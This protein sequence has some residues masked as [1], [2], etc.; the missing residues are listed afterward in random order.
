MKVW[1][2][3]PNYSKNIN[4]K[5]NH[6]SPQIIL[7]VRCVDMDWIVDHYWLYCLYHNHSKNIALQQTPYIPNLIIVCFIITFKIMTILQ[8]VIEVLYHKSPQTYNQTTK[9]LLF[10]PQIFYLSSHI[11]RLCNAWSLT[12]RSLSYHG[13]M[14]SCSPYKKSGGVL[15]TNV[16]C[17]FFLVLI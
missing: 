5:N 2:G 17:C 15:T 7:I 8:I 6:N 16:I 11:V 3:I 12:I 4:R 1:T 13:F 9:I 14:Q 10:I